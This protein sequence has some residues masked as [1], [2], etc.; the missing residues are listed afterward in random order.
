M[1]LRER[2][3]DPWA[4]LVGA[5]A[6]GLTWAVVPAGGLGVG[7]GVA[8]AAAVYGVKVAGD[9]LFDRRR[10]GPPEPP[11]GEQ[12]WPAELPEPPR[13]SEARRLLDRTEAALRSLDSTVA[14][15]GEGFTAEQLRP[16][17]E[18]ARGTHEAVRRL[19]GR[20]TTFDRAL[21]R[22]PAQRLFVERKRLAAAARE[23]RSA[24]A[25]AEHQAS[26]EA[27][28]EQL[29]VRERLLAARET[30]LAR[31][32]SAALGIESLDARAVELLALATSTG[33]MPD[34]AAGGAIDELA[35]E[36]EALRGG[37]VEVEQLTRRSVHPD[38]D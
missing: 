19:A 22:I 33:D 16:V 1:G 29:Q 37:L 6:G 9:A 32:Q 5:V 27:V 35:E 2:L 36:L 4:A 21:S 38:A 20:A 24:D 8:V 23:A 18:K 10:S 11:A 13:D 34:G 25:R 28:E 17:S 3:A 7:L 30:A 15:G 12:A 26:L 31:L 14:G